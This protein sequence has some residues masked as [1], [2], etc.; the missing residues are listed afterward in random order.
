[1][2]THERYDPKVLQQSVREDEDA[3]GGITAMWYNSG[4]NTDLLPAP[5]SLDCDITLRRYWYAVHNTLLQGAITNLIKRVVATPWELSGGKIL[6][7]RYQDVLQNAEFGQGYKVA[8]TKVLTDYYTQNGGGFL[9]IIGRGAKDKPMRGGAT[10]IAHL[11]RRRCVLTG[12]FE[13]PVI[14]Y[15]DRTGREHLLHHTRVVHFVDMPSPE[16]SVFNMGMCALYRAITISNAQI[17]MG[18]YQNERLSNEPPAGL[19]TFS[20]VKP[21]DVEDFQQ[22]YEADRLRKGTMTYAPLMQMSSLSPEQPIKVEFIPFSQ[23]P[24]HFDY[25]EYMEI[26]VNMLALAIGVDPQDIWPLTGAPL[27]TGAQSAILNAKGQGKALA[28]AY[29]M[30]E[31]AFNIWVLPRDLEFQ[32]KSKDAAADKQ[33]ADTAAQWVNMTTALLQSGQVDVETANRL[34]AER[35]EAFK[36]ALLDEAGNVR[37]PDD[38]IKP[39][40]ETIAEDDTTLAP[41]NGTPEAEAAQPPV[42]DAEAEE[43]DADDDTAARK[44]VPA[45]ADAAR[46][47]P[48]RRRLVS[49][50]RRPADVQ[51]KDYLATETEFVRNLT[52][53]IEAGLSDDMTRRRFGTVMRAQLSRLGRRAY[54]DGLADGGVVVD[55][56]DGDDL[57]IIGAWLAE[58]SRYVTDFANRVFSGDSSMT[59]EARAIAWA[60]KSLDGIYQRGLLEADRNGM[61]RWR[62]GPTEESCKDCQRLDNQVH[63]LRDWHKNGWTPRA[64]KLACNGFN[65]RC[66][67]VKTTGR[68][69]G[70][71]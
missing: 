8:L 21:T 24:D 62:V 38:D 56:L 50:L 1:M 35:V 11:D 26:H 4:Y 5:F 10:G 29:Q 7:R 6:T 47:A 2:T 60:N 54:Q 59:P 30:L 31:R 36:D 37:L 51:T 39:D 45:P 34:L 69:K 65:C 57:A 15:S 67:L 25:R 61:Y 52:E 71:Y 33:E 46:D 27:G 16:E 58:Q 68:A 49:D 17:L 43:T 32:F 44:S 48:G 41:D 20:N 22:R 28:D 40:R 13:H 64:S 3:H 55:S 53:L 9:E 23:L 14:Y 63:R 18:R 70:R 19:V 42:P 12:N 66:E